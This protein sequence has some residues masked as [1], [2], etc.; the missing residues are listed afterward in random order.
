M[1][2]TRGDACISTDPERLSIDLIHDY[3][4]NSSYWASGRHF[5]TVKKSIQ[6]SLNFGVYQAGKQ[7]G[8]ARVVTDYSTFFWLCDVFIL[9]EARGQGLGKWLIWCVV[10][11]PDLAGLRGFLMTRDARTLYEPYGFKS[12]SNPQ[13]L[14]IRAAGETS[15][16]VAP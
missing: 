10:N 5:D 12:P 11:T 1:E 2:W 15:P 6:N 16:E 4:S 3:L 8:F 7:V 14:M 9:P 13:R